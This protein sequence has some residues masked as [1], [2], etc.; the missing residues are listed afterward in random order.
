[1]VFQF[2]G[3]M[4]LKLKVKDLVSVKSESP[5]LPSHSFLEP[6]PRK[7]GLAKT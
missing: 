4:G 5:F 3:L 1:M 2:Q 6:I 7:N